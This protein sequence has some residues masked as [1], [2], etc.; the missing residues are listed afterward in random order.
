MI[1]FV[2]VFVIQNLSTM[3]RIFLFFLISWLFVAS[4]AQ[5]TITPSTAL[6]AYLNN[7]D[8][9]NAWELRDHYTVGNTQAYSL[10]FISQ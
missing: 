9:S 2:S 10:F 5:L 1:T 6:D 8:P 3:K 7:D 4:Y